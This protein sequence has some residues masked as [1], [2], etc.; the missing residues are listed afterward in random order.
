MCTIEDLI[1]GIHILCG[2]SCSFNI[3]CNI[4]DTIYRLEEFIT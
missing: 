4:Q 2:L 1:I 3:V